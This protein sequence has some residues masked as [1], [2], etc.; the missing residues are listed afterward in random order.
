MTKQGSFKRAV[1]N[2]RAPGQRYTEALADLAIAR[3]TGIRQR[4][5]V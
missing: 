3:T 4:P 1:R 2:G 5:A